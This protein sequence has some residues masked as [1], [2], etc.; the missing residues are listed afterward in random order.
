MKFKETKYVGF[1]GTRM[2]MASW[3]PENEKPRA[4]MIAIHG[5]GSH[6]L[7]LETIGEFMAEKGIALFAPD[8][9]G[10]GHFAGQ[11]GHVMRFNEYIEDIQNLVMQVKDRYLNKL[12]YLF[13]ASLGGLMVL[14]YVMAYRKTVDG[15]LLH[16]PAVAQTQN[17][18]P[19]KKF[20]VRLLS[21]L[22]VKMYFEG[23]VDYA[24][25]SRNPEIVKRHQ[26]DRLRVQGVTARFG[27]EALKASEQTFKE[28][29]K[30][31]LPVLYQQAGE[32]KLISPERSKQFFESIASKDKTFRMYKGLYHELHEEPEKDMVF[33]DMYGW[34]Q[35]RLPS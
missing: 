22:N 2:F 4:L 5:L 3:I 11:K 6:G 30:I 15:I 13:G 10:F 25:G 14:R 9:R 27:I 7:D 17:I 20:F 12:T 29:S 34:L 26:E 1:D 35:K 28:G 23:E 33:A 21:L 16:C 8:M 24:D 32:D 31:V 18:N 19:I